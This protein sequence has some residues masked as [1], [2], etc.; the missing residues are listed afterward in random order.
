VVAIYHDENVCCECRKLELMKIANFYWRICERVIAG[1][2]DFPTMRLRPCRVHFQIAASG[3]DSPG[4]GQTCEGDVVRLRPTTGDVH[5]EHGRV[6]ES[7]KRIELRAE[8]SGIV[9]VGGVVN[10]DSSG[11]MND[12]SL[13]VYF[14]DWKS[15]V[16]HEGIYFLDVVAEIA[17][18][19]KGIPRGH[20]DRDF[21]SNVRNRHGDVK[22]MIFWLSERNFVMDSPQCTRRSRPKRNS[23]GQDKKEITADETAHRERTSDG[24][25]ESAP[26][27]FMSFPQRPSKLPFDMI[28]RRSPRRA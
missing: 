4:I 24:S 11:R 28:S 6:D 9:P 2:S 22:Q 19:I 27:F 10:R 21:A 7:V 23:E 16:A 12:P 17:N 3:L 15:H 5:K 25:S 18:L 14:F 20:L 26:S 13:L 8:G 1:R